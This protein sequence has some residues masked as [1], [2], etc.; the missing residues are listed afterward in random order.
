MS[1]KESKYP[2]ADMGENFDPETMPD[3]EERALKGDFAFMEVE[4]IRRVY[5][6]EEME[7]VEAREVAESMIPPP[8][9]MEDEE[10]GE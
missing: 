7:R 5:V 4:D 1:K 9:E 3:Y 6:N 8:E 10:G 2:I